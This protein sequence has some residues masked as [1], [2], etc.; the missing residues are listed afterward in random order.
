MIGWFSGGHFLYLCVWLSI[1][2]WGDNL[3]VTAHDKGNSNAYIRSGVT[4]CPIRWMV[5]EEMWCIQKSAR[6]IY[7]L[8][9]LYKKKKF[10]LLTAFA[11]LLATLGLTSCAKVDYK[12]DADWIGYTEHGIASFYARN[13]QHKKTASG[14]RFDHSRLSAAHKEIPFG[15]KVKVTNIKNKKSVV[16]RINDRGPFVRGRIID[17]SRQA[18]S[19]IA[20]T[21]QGIVKVKLEVVQ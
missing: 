15:A 2:S 7:Q 16:V 20:S 19:R 10:L 14:E 8:P 17:L 21:R 6:G 1:F 12:S 5:T 18:F 9:I 13:F 4:I 11:L 3:F